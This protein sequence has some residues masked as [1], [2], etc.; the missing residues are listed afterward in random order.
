[1]PISNTL[2]FSLPGNFL[3]ATTASEISNSL[4][5]SASSIPTNSNRKGLTI[6]N[7]LNVAIYVDIANTVSTTNFMFKLEAGAFYEMPQPAFTG[8]LHMICES[9]TGSVEIREFA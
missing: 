2:N 6:F 9:G 1:M 3:P 7:T 5:T 8:A 4:S